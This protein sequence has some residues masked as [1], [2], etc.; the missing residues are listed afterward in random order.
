VTDDADLDDQIAAKKTE[1]AALEQRRRA[2][3]Q[4]AIK[5]AILALVDDWFEACEL[6]ARLPWSQS[7]SAT[8]GGLSP[9]A[10]GRRLKAIADADDRAVDVPTVRLLRLKT[11]TAATLWK[12]ETYPPACGLHGRGR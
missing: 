12:I 11:T 7:L 9:K 2:R 4:A 6:C 3:D 1:L 5:L 10:I 8:W